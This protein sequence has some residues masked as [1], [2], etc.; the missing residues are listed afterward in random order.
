MRK[1]S[2]EA[3]S[4]ESESRELISHLEEKAEGKDKDFI[5]PQYPSCFSLTGRRAHARC[6]NHL[7]VL[8][9]SKISSGLLATTSTTSTTRPTLLR[10]ALTIHES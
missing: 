7:Q 9:G 4:F 1:R 5:Y 6:H 3:T 2:G 10:S 8:S